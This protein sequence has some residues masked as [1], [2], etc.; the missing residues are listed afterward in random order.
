MFKPS[1]P[2][3]ENVGFAV[4]SHIEQ[5]LRSDAISWV[6]DKVLEYIRMKEQANGLERQSL[7]GAEALRYAG[8]VVGSSRAKKLPH[9]NHQKKSQVS[10][11]LS[12]VLYA[13][14]ISPGRPPRRLIFTNPRF[15]TRARCN[16]FDF[17]QSRCDKT[18]LHL[19]ANYESQES[20]RMRNAHREL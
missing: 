19:L 3:G 1:K 13:S 6:S 15:L 12:A 8:W 10:S 14:R 5:R 18:A 7:A 2:S 17:A 9:H 16:H 11:T 20:S 4:H